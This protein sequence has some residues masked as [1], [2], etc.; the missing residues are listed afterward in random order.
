MTRLVDLD[1]VGG[2]RFLRELAAALE[3]RSPEARARS[4]LDGAALAE[5]VAMIAGGRRPTTGWWRKRIEKPEIPGRRPPS[6]RT[7]ERVTAGMVRAGLPERAVA[8]AVVEM[9]VEDGLRRG[10]AERA[11]ARGIAAGRRRLGRRRAA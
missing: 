4:A 7:L 5:L 1:T 2:P 6:T 3:G 10:I 8:Q 11:C 9:A